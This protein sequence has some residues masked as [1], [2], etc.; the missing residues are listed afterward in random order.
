MSLLRN[1][2]LPEP[3][4]R[5]IQRSR[6][7]YTG[8]GLDRANRTVSV[9][10][11]LK[12][13]RIALL[14]EKYDDQ[15]ELN[16]SDML[17]MFYGS[18]V[19]SAISFCR[20][21]VLETHVDRLTVQIPGTTWS[22]SGQ[23][24]DYDPATST[25]QDWKFTSVFAVKD[26]KPEWGLQLNLYRWLMKSVDVFPK[27]LKIV[28]LLRDWGPRHKV[29]FPAPVVEIPYPMVSDEDLEQEMVERIADLNRPPFDPL[30][31]CSEE[32]R[33]ASQKDPWKRCDGYCA[34]KKFCSQRAE[35]MR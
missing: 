1:D 8:P 27:K 17:W 26:P 14:E 22:L 7:A 32:E 2:G 11:L 23:I 19:H 18:A 5:A 13:P 21:D 35:G 28:A 31:N 4:F 24:D 10:T 16:A 30:P 20:E 6:N 15:I 34:V 33:W 9:T 25:L 29:D 3:I 12:P